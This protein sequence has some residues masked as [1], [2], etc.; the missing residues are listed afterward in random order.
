MQIID[1]NLG[2]PKSADLFMFQRLPA[3][4]H[5]SN[6]TCWQPQRRVVTPLL[7]IV[8]VKILKEGDTI[9]MRITGSPDI[10]IIDRVA[11]QSFF[12]QPVLFGIEAFWQIKA[13]TP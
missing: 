3:L 11:I 5:S 10:A 1:H 8:T 13:G 7:D 12:W 6:S 4:V 2:A 9:S